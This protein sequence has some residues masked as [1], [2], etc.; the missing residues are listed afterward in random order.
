MLPLQANFYSLV[1][2]SSTLLPAAFGMLTAY[3]TTCPLARPTHNVRVRGAGRQRE[4]ERGV[5]GGGGG[6]GGDVGGVM[7]FCCKG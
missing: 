2:W 3:D 1:G 6:G 7:R 5:V 4:R